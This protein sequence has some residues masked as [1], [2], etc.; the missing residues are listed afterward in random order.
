MPDGRRVAPGHAPGLARGALNKGPPFSGARP[1][2]TRGRN[3]SRMASLPPCRLCDP[4][5]SGLPTHCR[6][7]LRDRAG[8]LEHPGS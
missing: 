7:R 1:A 4:A 8:G 5:A 6:R 2:E 3:Q